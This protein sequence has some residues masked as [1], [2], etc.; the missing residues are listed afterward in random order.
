M[1]SGCLVTN[2]S[3]SSCLCHLAL[4]RVAPAVPPEA[5]QCMYIANL[6]PVNCS[7]LL[8]PALAAAAGCLLCVAGALSD[9]SVQ[10]ANV[11]CTGPQAP[12]PIS[13]PGA[14]SSFAPG[15]TGV[16][17]TQA[18]SDMGA[19]LT[20]ADLPYPLSIDSSNFTALSG[21]ILFSNSTIRSV[22]SS[23]QTLPHTCPVWNVL[24]CLSS[25]LQKA[26]FT[27]NAGAQ[28][29]GPRSLQWHLPC[30]GGHAA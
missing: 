8:A 14:V 9:I 10:I 7:R 20:I 22:R 25:R 11:S 27:S 5:C 18:V 4:T 13:G 16:T 12:V 19:I 24:L 6:Q 17:F 23:L 30:A 1:F 15:F 26:N 29:G 3:G 21:S 2:C 28:A